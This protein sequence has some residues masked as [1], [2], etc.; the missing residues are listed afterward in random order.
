VKIQA[1]RRRGEGWV[2]ALCG[3]E[4]G[5][6]AAGPVAD[7]PASARRLRSGGGPISAARGG[8]PSEAECRADNELSLHR[9]SL[10]YLDGFPSGSA[11]AASVTASIFAA[12]LVRWAISSSVT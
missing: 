1:G 2:Q 9:A 11:R 3:N 5:S 4:Q 8:K 7:Y 10:C 6:L 12:K